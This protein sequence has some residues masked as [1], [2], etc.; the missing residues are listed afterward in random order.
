MR[1]FEVSFVGSRLVVIICFYRPWLTSSSFV[2][3]D[4]DL[5]VIVDMCSVCATVASVF[6][7]L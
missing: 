2:N 5:E 4:G 7:L 3:A 1:R 6:C